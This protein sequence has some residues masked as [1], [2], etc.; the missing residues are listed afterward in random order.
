VDIELKLRFRTFLFSL[1]LVSTSHATL[2]NISKAELFEAVKRGDSL[3]RNVDCK[4]TI[5][6]QHDI[7]IWA[8]TEISLKRNL[9]IQSTSYKQKDS[10]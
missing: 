1:L 4:Y 8:G 6:D 2:L 9:H 5:D 7:S 10:P 3:Y